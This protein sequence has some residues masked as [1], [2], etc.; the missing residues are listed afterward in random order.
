MSD[1]GIPAIILSISGLPIH[2]DLAFHFVVGPP[3][4]H[5]CSLN[6]TETKNVDVRRCSAA[7]RLSIKGSHLN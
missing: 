7:D 5:A 6:A 4:R 1:I 3:L 2:E